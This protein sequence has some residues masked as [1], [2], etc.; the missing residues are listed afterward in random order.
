MA[1]FKIS[2]DNGSEFFLSCGVPDVEFN[3]L[4]LE[5]DIFH[6]EINSGDLGFLAL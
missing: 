1:S 3:R 4:S 6:F 2:G 5:G